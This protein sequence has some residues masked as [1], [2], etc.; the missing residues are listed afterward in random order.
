[1]IPYAKFHNLDL[2]IH[3]INKLS[4]SCNL[5]INAFYKHCFKVTDAVF[6][7][8]C[9]CTTPYW[10]IKYLSISIIE[11]HSKFAESALNVISPKKWT[12]SE[13]AIAIKQ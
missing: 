1:M 12:I 9:T 5:C 3:C 6:N 10:Q 4:L 2:Q 8:H 13:C 11:C 7:I